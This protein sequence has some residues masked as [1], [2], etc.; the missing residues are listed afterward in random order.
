M[1]KFTLT[2]LCALCILGYTYGQTFTI[3][4]FVKSAQSGESLIGAAVYHRT[5]LKGTVS[6]PFGF[7]SLSLPAADTVT[8]LCSYLGFQPQLISLVAARDTNLVIRLLPD[9]TMLGEVEV[10]AD[11]YAEVIEQSTQMSN[12]SIPVQQIKLLPALLGEVD[13]IKVLQLMPGVQSGTEGGSGLYVR[14][15]GPDQNLILLDGVPVY[16]V[17]HLFGF[18]SIFNSDA[19]NHVELIKGGF[20]ARYGGR[21]SSVLDISLKEGNMQSFHGE[22]SIGLISSKLTLEGPLVKDKASFMVSGRRTYIDFLARPLIKAST[23]GDETVGYHFHDI[24]AK[25]NYKISNK[26][27]VYLSLYTGKDKAYSIFNSNYT[28][29]GNLTESRE[30]FGLRWGNMIS[31]LRW[32]HVFGKKLFSN[33]TLTYSQYFFDLF[34]EDFTTTRNA[35]GVENRFYNEQYLSGIKDWAAKMDFDYYPGSNHAIKFGGNAIYH[36]F[37]PGALSLVDDTRVETLA[38]SSVTY[39]TEVAAYVEDD[40]KISERLSANI[41]LHASAF[42][43]NGTTYASLQ[44]RVAARYLLPNRW[45]IKASY[46]EMAQF[47]HLLSNAGIGLPT[48]LWVPA[49]GRV[50]PQQAIQMALGTAKTFG[51]YELSVEVYYKKLSDIIEYK[52]GASFIDL[53][54]DW[55]EKIEVGQGWSYGAEF[56]FQK[57]TG[58]TTGWIGYT[59]SW[60]DRQFQELNFGQRF[61]YRFDRRHDLSFAMVH[62]I[63]PNVDFSLAWV[64]GTGNAVTLATDLYE[65]LDSRIFALFG[66]G[67]QVLGT[68]MGREITHYEGRNTFRM[69][70]YHRLD[71]SFGFKKQ[72][73]HGLR[74]WTVGAYNLYSRL[75]PFFIERSVNNNGDPVFKQYSLFPII[76]SVNYSFK[77]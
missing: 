31:A 27:R 46:A 51:K 61:P 48:D 8:L 76:P 33:L 9:A 26:D 60:A 53:D 52:E 23:G 47:I 59:L 62:A 55:Q 40:M 39:A 28:W 36:T 29:E 22:G 67:G 10:T 54:A 56:L 15:G 25:L 72:K 17:S 64:Y 65:P 71:V 11:R 34:Y 69:R 44:P 43:V 21:L 5:S 41:G 35:Q 68:G 19:I 77:F 30:E 14:G 12:I 32:N 45:A 16:N 6:N 75:N 1:K 24:N 50:R 49:T 42:F 3:S 73:K 38:G 7:F 58:R 66:A 63:K 18:F 20:P 57:K 37:T 2:C 13:L 70:A 4:G 74:T